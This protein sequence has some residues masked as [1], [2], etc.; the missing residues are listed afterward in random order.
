LALTRN[1]PAT[2]VAIGALACVAALLLAGLWPFAITANAGEFHWIPFSGNLLL[3][4]DY[5]PLLDQIFLYA[6][7]LWALTLS[8]G[9]L[10]FAFVAALMLITAIEL[11]Q[12]WMPDRRAEITDPLLVVLLAGAFAVA[13]RFQAHAF[14]VE[15]PRLASHRLADPNHH[16]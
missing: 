11:G 13:R 8:F 2:R 3:T 5:R 15:N 12:L 10:T 16:T 14:G 9:R 7:L 1:A 4:R 6:A